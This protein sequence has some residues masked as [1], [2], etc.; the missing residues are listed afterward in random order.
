MM[1]KILIPPGRIQGGFISITMQDR[2]R[3]LPGTV[4]GTFYGVRPG[5]AVSPYIADN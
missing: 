2:R 3:V 5:Q 4:P 1:T